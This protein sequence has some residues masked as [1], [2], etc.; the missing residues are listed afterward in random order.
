M[1]SSFP[2]KLYIII[3]E[4]AKTEKEPAIGKNRP[5]SCELI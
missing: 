1:V 3:S 2:A 4:H 5:Y